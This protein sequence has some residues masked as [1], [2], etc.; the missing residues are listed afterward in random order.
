MRPLHGPHVRQTLHRSDQRPE[1]GS[2]ETGTCHGGRPH[3]Q[4]NFRRFPIAGPGTQQHPRTQEPGAGR[5]AGQ[6]LGLQ[7]P[8]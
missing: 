5:T 4:G 3:T 8:F 1:G 7:R 6:V 2:R